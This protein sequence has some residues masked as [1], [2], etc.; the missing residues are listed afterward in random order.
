MAPFDLS[1]C[2]VSHREAEEKDEAEVEGV[3]MDVADE[4]APP[5]KKRR[6]TFG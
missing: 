1:T 5:S 3:L 2:R 4:L 6:V